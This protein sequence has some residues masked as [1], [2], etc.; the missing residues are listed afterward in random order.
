MT[1][2]KTLKRIVLAGMALGALLSVILYVTDLPPLGP[3][4]TDSRLDGLVGLAHTT[5]FMLLFDALLWGA[6]VAFW[7][8]G[9]SIFQQYEASLNRSI[10]TL[11]SL[12]LL[13]E[14][15]QPAI[16]ALRD[17]R[18]KLT[19]EQYDLVQASMYGGALAG[20]N[21]GLERIAK[22]DPD[23]IHHWL[24]IWEGR[25]NGPH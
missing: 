12:S 16:E 5:I 18:G 4:L 24:E 8:E 19:P 13:V 11:E 17:Y 6:T 20:L 3:W 7:S 2:L 14:Y 15:C 9:T 21:L 23:L 10:K 1:S 25:R 22:N